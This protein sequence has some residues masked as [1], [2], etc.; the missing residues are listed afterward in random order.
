MTDLTQESLDAA[1][2]E[3]RKLPNGGCLPLDDPAY[4]ELR[5]RLWRMANPDAAFIGDPGGKKAM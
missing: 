2:E 1:M 5:W 4:V 3:L